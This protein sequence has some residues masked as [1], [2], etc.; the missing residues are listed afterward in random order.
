MAARQEE[1]ADIAIQALGLTASIIGVGALIYLT[2]T[3]TD[4]MATAA[5]LTYGATLIAMFACSILNATV[6][7]P[8]RRS[9]VRLLDHSVIYFLIAGTY[10]PFCL[11]AIGG[12]R[13]ADLLLGVW[14]AACLGVLIR[15][16]SHRR[17]KSAVIT[18]YVLLGWSGLIHLDLILQRVTGTALMLLA[19]GGV[20]YTIG[21]PIHR[22]SGLRYHS[23]IWHTCVLAAAACHYGAILLILTTFHGQSVA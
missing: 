23:A 17:L 15:I 9:M 14:V 11:L 13:G 1:I 20:L 18:L 6:R 4:S 10:T 16:L 19:L 8:V 5:A 22:W 7:H 3:W 12:P 2:V 21:A